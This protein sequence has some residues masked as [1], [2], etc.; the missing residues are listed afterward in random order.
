MRCRTIAA[1]IAVALAFAVNANAAPLPVG[2][3][4][5]SGCL[6]AAPSSTCTTGAGLGEG[7]SGVVSADGTSAYV[8][9]PT[10]GSEATLLVL[11]RAASGQLTEAACFEDTGGTQ[12]GAGHQLPSFAYADDVALSPD[13]RNVYV[14]IEGTATA[15]GMLQIFNRAA[16]GSLTPAGCWDYTAGTDCG[17]GHTTP[18]LGDPEGIVV[19][20]DGKDVYVA[21]YDSRAVITFARAADGSLTPAGCIQDPGGGNAGAPGL[22]CGTSTTPGMKG[23]TGIAIS[24]NGASVYVAGFSSSAL[25]RFNRST[26]GVLTP[27]GCIQE[28]GGTDCGA[29]NTTHGLDEANSVAISPDGQNV[30]THSADVG[31]PLAIFNRAADG[32]LTPVT[33]IAGA[34]S[35]ECPTK[36]PA[37]TG[38]IVTPDTIT[39][40][41]DGRTVYVASNGI[42]AVLWFA[43]ASDGSLTP[44]GCFEQ[45]GTDCAG[46]IAPDLAGANGVFTAP[47]GDSVYVLGD[48]GVAEFARG[49]APLC[50]P[51]NVATSFGTPVAIALKCADLHGDPITIATAANPAHGTLGPV[52]QATGAV[53]YTPAA[54][55]SGTDTFSFAAS[56]GVNSSAPSTATIAV[57]PRPMVRKLK[58]SP[59]SFVSLRHGGVTI[60]SKHMRLPRGSRVSFSLNVAVRVSFSVLRPASGRRSKH[61]CAKATSH[62]RQAKRCTRFVRVGGFG[63]NARA[64]ATKFK[65]S[66]RARHK[67]LAPGRYRLAGTPAGGK[68]ASV[69]F[70]ILRG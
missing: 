42:G 29:T 13:G 59:K 45:A 32:S 2:A 40:A 37:N 41:P 68:A 10:S 70:R 60:A 48:S 44:S 3:L 51:A 56:D 64:G 50:A 66:G 17:S 57:G 25:V 6:T 16:D 65:F 7:F 61:G 14:T 19:S 27:A 43:R 62:N 24:S 34:T 35:T 58:L 15:D 63:L 47:A 39:V 4:A 9:Q 67:P 18:G 55:F 11:T 33:C 69:S 31:G 36:A 12:C 21:A 1:V 38:N 23:A 20:P 22:Q 8:V 5:P 30:Y 49:V 28:T 54:G 53:T 52:N 46:N 26:S